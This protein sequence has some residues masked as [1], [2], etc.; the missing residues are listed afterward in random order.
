MARYSACLRV[1]G[2]GAMAFALVAAAAAQHYTLPQIRYRA[3]PSPGAPSPYL[4][5]LTPDEFYLPS[6]QLDVQPRLDRETLDRWQYR[7]IESLQFKMR[8]LEQS[9][10]LPPGPIDRT[11][12]HGWERPPA[13]PC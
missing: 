3:E 1:L 13:A 9:A 6:Y 2:S 12:R 11:L 8:H 5:L 7:E 4:N 10:L